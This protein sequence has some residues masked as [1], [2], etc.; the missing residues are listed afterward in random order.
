M[1]D[2]TRL[3]APAGEIV[4]A[5]A[6]ATRRV[7]GAVGLN[8]TGDTSDRATIADWAP[9]VDCGRVAVFLDLEGNRWDLLGPP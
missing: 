7:A 4:R 3:A 8:D 6:T 1:P 5:G 9:R 2:A